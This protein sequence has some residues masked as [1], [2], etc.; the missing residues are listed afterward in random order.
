[1]QSIQTARLLLFLK[2]YKGRCLSS[3]EIACCWG[4]VMSRPFAGWCKFGIGQVYKGPPARERVRSPVHRDAHPAAGT[5]A[6]PAAQAADDS[7][8]RI[9]QR[10]DDSGSGGRVDTTGHVAVDVDAQ[11]ERCVTAASYGDNISGEGVDWVDPLSDPDDDVHDDIVRSS[12]R[13]CTEQQQQGNAAAGIHAADT[14]DTD[15]HGHLSY[16]DEELDDSDV[17]ALLA[18]LDAAYSDIL[19][20]IGNITTPEPDACSSNKERVQ[21][22]RE[23]LHEKVHPHARETLIEY[24]VNM[25]NFFVDST[26]SRNDFNNLL[27]HN[28]DKL[29]GAENNYAPTSLALVSS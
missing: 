5:A 18:Q 7:P 16:Q 13:H 29:L 19:D 10:Q 4:V 14:D 27:K 2:D 20:T 25:L 15:Y 9:R 12:V 21:A 17:M 8:Q 23:R 26:V 11:P 24:I 3:R 22:Y 1:M 28:H 6:V